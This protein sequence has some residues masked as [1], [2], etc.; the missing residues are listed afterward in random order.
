MKSV[1]ILTS[2]I[3]LFAW[4]S[5]TSGRYYD[6]TKSKSKYGLQLDV[7][8]NPY[9]AAQ[10]VLDNNISGRCFSD[11]LTS[12]YL[13][14]RLQPDFKTF[15]DLRDLDVFP[16]SFFGAFQRIVTDASEFNKADSIY[17]FDYVILFRAQFAS[18]HQYLSR[19]PGYSLVFVDEVA[20]VYLK[21]EERFKPLISKYGFNDCSKDLFTEQRT[22]QSSVPS[23]FVS[24]LFNPFY[25]P[26]HYENALIETAASEFYSDINCDSLALLRITNAMNENNN[27]DI[28]L[29]QSGLV[30]LKMVGRTVDMQQRIAYVE[31]AE[32]DFNKAL[33]INSENP[34]ALTGTAQCRMMKGEREKVLPLLQQAVRI[35]KSDALALGLLSDVYE[36]L[37]AS[38]SNMA[39]DYYE[40]R[41]EVLI[42]LDKLTPNNPNVQL[43]VALCFSRLKRCSDAKIWLQRF[44]GFRNFNSIQMKELNEVE[45][46]CH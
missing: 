20:A 42:A 28:V 27:S 8:A 26:H 7:G 13:M 37:A 38:N 17:K 39:G 11:Y 46:N 24:G 3:G 18:L 2:V 44:K 25:K 16:V 21:N 5:I 10:F 35:N 45:Q 1:V 32:T 33:E 9:G 36:D 29:T 19:T 14:W 23:S 12:S 41:A 30:N 4:Y 40:K 34:T 31:K 22:N 15:I 6:L 43:Q